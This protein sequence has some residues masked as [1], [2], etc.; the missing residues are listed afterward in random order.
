MKTKG[1]AKPKTT[2]EGLLKIDRRLATIIASIALIWL[3][4]FKK[5]N[6]KLSKL[7]EKK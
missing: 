6:I 1:N 3:Y 7:S 5:I 2:A 4:G